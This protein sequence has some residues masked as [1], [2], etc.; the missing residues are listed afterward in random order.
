MSMQQREQVY[1]CPVCRNW[2]ID[3]FGLPLYGATLEGPG[4]HVAG[5]FGGTAYQFPEIRLIPSIWNHQLEEALREHLETH[6][7]Q[8]TVFFTQVDRL[9]EGGETATLRRELRLAIQATR[10]PFV[11]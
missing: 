2:Q 9:T 1:E 4:A 10:E 6:L 3:A 7:V 5:G 8:L 11:R